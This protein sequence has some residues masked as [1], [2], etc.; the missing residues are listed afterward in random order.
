MRLQATL[1]AS[2][3]LLAAAPTANA[4]LSKTGNI[5]LFSDASCA[6]AVFVNSW[7]LGSDFCAGV[8]SASWPV[9]VAFQSYILNERPG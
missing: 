5:T 7:T 6:D 2:A 3:A 8:D 9:D 1:A 4:N